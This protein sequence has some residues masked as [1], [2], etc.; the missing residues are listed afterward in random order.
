MKLDSI[1]K[2]Y[3]YTVLSEDSIDRNPFRQF[4]KWMKEALEAEVNEPTAMGLSAIGAD[5]F[6]DSRI[7]LLKDFDENGF[8]FFTNYNSLKGKSIQQ[9]PAVSL[10]FF[11][12]E[13]ERQIR[14]SGY[15]RK[16][17]TTISNLY[18]QSRPANSRIAAAVSNQSEKIPSRDFLENHFETAKM[19]EPPIRPE[20]WGGYVVKPLRIE[21]WQGR[22][23]RLHD[24]I[25]FKKTGD[26]W[27]ISRLAP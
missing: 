5:G 1:R 18:F 19:N 2:E 26:L 12:P 21:F 3:R 27:T 11:W 17:D 7:V 14:I 9:N 22:E 10:L 6:P 20:H 24:R 25:L 15:A 4:E 16:T 23:S 13:L 8:T